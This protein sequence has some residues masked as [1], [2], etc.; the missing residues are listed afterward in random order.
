[1]RPGRRQA[2]AADPSR[3]LWPWPVC[4]GL[5]DSWIAEP[6]GS[7]TRGEGEVVSMRLTWRDAAATLLVGAATAVYL[8]QK[9]SVPIPLITDRGDVAAGALLLGFV[10]CVIDEWTVKHA[11]LVRTLS[12]LSVST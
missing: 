9:L 12:V 2:L 6:V 11:A 3:D 8:G 4:I 10:A 7:T 1:M 5:R